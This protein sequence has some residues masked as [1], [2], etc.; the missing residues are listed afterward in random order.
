[1][2]NYIRYKDKEGM[3]QTFEQPVFVEE[4]ISEDADNALELGA[5]DK[6]FVPK[7]EADEVEAADLISEDAE[8]VLKTGMDKKLFVPKP[9]DV[10]AEDLISA[11]ANNGIVLGADKKL[12][13]PK[14]GEVDANKLLFSV[15]PYLWTP[16][17]EHDFGDGTFGKRYVN[18]ATGGGDLAFDWLPDG[19]RFV[20]A[21][22]NYTYVQPSG[23]RVYEVL[24]PRIVVDQWNGDYVSAPM[25]VATLV[26]CDVW[27]RY[28]KSG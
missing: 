13:A 15:K 6:L 28:K 12:F 4:F 1:M 26:E 24:V 2:G 25:P 16:Y 27:I 5:D 19:L 7:T 9:T 18:E 3:V 21:G 23:E 22:G 11:D 8:N 14:G 20:D 10:K 17:I